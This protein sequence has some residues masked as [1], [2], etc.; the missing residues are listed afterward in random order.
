MELNS[1]KTKNIGKMFSQAS[2]LFEYKMEPK[3]TN[4]V[5]FEKMF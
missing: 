4:K 1:R 2:F 3:E 5:I